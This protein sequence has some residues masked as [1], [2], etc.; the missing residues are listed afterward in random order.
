VTVAT[1]TSKGQVTIPASVRKACGLKAGSRLDFVVESDDVIIVR[2]K[3]PSLADLYGSL[4]NSG[5]H[6]TI[7]EMDDAIGDAIAEKLGLL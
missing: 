1:L 2:T 4:P 6:L 3:V 7:D 5:I